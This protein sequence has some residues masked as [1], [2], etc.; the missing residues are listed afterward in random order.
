MAEHVRL[1]S[2]KCA[3][4]QHL[5]EP[6]AALERND[7]GHLTLRVLLQDSDPAMLPIHMLVLNLQHLEVKA[8]KRRR[9][10][11]KA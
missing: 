9:N 8:A 5:L 1:R 2:E 7:A 10:G 6:A 3:T 11:G 4:P